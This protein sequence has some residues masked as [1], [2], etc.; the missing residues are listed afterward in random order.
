MSNQVKEIGCML[1]ALME[2]FYD[3][4]NWRLVIARIIHLCLEY[5]C[6]YVAGAGICAYW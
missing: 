5:L 6:L 1:S 4:L 2:Q 3:D